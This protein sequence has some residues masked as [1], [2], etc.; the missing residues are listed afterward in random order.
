LLGEIVREIAASNEDGV[1]CYPLRKY[2]VSITTAD[3]RGAG[4]D[5]QVS[6]VLYGEQVIYNNNNL[7]INHTC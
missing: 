5:G 1:A 7:P 2:R 3:I 6:I 4:T